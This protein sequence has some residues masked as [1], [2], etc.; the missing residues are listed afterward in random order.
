MRRFKYSA[1][2]LIL[3]L[4]SL[5]LKI[6][7]SVF[8]KPLSSLRTDSQDKVKFKDTKSNNLLC[9]KFSYTYQDYNRLWRSRSS[10]NL[11]NFFV[12][13]GEQL[14]VYLQYDDCSSLILL[15]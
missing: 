6:L 4:S 13:S 15:I 12:G 2:N 9:K 7:V 8:R 14:D 11:G 3:S 1:F 10:H 5:L